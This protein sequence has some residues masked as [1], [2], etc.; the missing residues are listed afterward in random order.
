VSPIALG[1]GRLLVLDGLLTLWITLAILS[2]Y[3]A[4]QYGARL[5]KRWWFIAALAC[6]LGVLTK[7]PIALVLVVVPVVVHR[8]LGRDDEAPAISWRAWTVFLFI[9]VAINLPW[10]VAVCIQRPEFARYF[11][12]QHNVQRFVEPFDHVRPVWFYLPIVLYGLLPITLLAWPIARFML[13]TRT[14]ESSARCP[15]MGYLLLSG[16]WCVFFF[17]LAGSKLPTYILPAFPP[18]CMGLGC[19]V[20]RTDWHRSRWVIGQIAVLWLAQA[21]VNNIAVPMWADAK[22]P[23]GEFETMR[24]RCA[25]P[26]VPVVCFPRNVDSVA[27]YVGRSDFRTF[28]SKDIGAAIQALEQAPRTVVLF[29]HRNSPETLA[30]HL[31]PHLRLVDRRPMGLCESGIV[32]R[33]R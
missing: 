16:L 14:E 22:S 1:V 24:E 5:Q 29:G 20:A 10:Y 4:Q 19:F 3:L 26:S 11:L 7:G 18:L 28:R 6:A 9:V 27:F 8:W 30:R 2:T 13:S 12:W 31:P 17:S 32:E 25:D 23:M 21:G 15:A 33:V